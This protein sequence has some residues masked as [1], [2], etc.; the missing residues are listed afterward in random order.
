VGDLSNLM[1]RNFTYVIA[2]R[3]SFNY[4]HTDLVGIS[5]KELVEKLSSSNYGFYFDEFGIIVLKYEYSGPQLMMVN[6][7]LVYE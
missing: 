2:D 4:N 1:S 3:Y 7:S 6:G 5:M